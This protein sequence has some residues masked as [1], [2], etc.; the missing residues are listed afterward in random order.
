[1]MFIFIRSCFQFSFPGKLIAF[2]WGVA[3]YD[4]S[5][6]EPILMNVSSRRL[7]VNQL[8]AHYGSEPLQAKTELMTYTSHEPA[9]SAQPH[10]RIHLRNRS[11]LAVIC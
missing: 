2:W 6:N 10:L 3:P 7:K 5:R 8:P 1:M 9:C 4:V 11:A